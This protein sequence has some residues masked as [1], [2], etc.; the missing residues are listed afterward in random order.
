MGIEDKANSLYE[1][2]YQ[3]SMERN[4]SPLSPEERESAQVLVD[5]FLSKIMD[6]DPNL[7][8]SIKVS[9]AVVRLAGVKTST[10]VAVR[11]DLYHGELLTSQQED[12]GLPILKPP[13]PQGFLRRDTIN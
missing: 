9:L 6:D 3:E 4:L 1:K 8:Q 7:L 2:T 12:G 5:D 10:D 11:L 13:P